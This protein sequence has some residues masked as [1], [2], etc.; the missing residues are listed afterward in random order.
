MVEVVATSGAVGATRSRKEKTEALADL[1][2]RVEV[3]ELATVVGFLAGEPRQGK[4]GV[5]WASVFGVDV[6]AA[7]EPR[8]EIAEI[9][10][11][12]DQLA[13][14]S[15]EGSQAARADQLA[16][17]MGRATV[18]EQDF[19]RRLFLGDMRHGALAGLMADAVAKAAGVPAKV[20]RRATML[21]GDLGGSAVLAMTGGRD[22]LAD[23]RLTPLR[24][25]Q[26]MLAGTAESPTAAIERNAVSSVEWKLDGVRIQVHRSGNDVRVFTRNLNDVTERMADVVDAA[27]A[28]DAESVVLDGEVVGVGPDGRPRPFQE[29]MSDFGRD[30]AESAA[31]DANVAEAEQKSEAGASWA[32]APFY[33]D[34]L[35]RDGRDLIDL[36]LIARRQELEA[37]VPEGQ[38]VPAVITGDADE[39]ERFFAAAVDAGHEGVVIKKDDSTYEAGRRGKTWLKVKPVHTLDLVVLAAEWGHGRRQGWLS[40]LHLG[41][42]DPESGE[43][44]MLGKTFKGLTDA[45]LTWQ[46]ERFLEIEDRRSSHIVFVRPELVVEIAFDG[47]MR[48]SRYPGGVSLRFARVKRYREDKSALDADTLAAVR[49][50]L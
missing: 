2:R 12:F 43:F 22:A 15:G 5:G 37:V 49:A 21:S 8:L 41:A 31:P 35:H 45:L 44:I 16:A 6:P 3:D 25:I 28:L 1:F 11:A 42:R 4:I 20:V 46:T 48:S 47:V 38:R 13:V 19:L 9:D 14:T 10:D 7:A 29:T 36:P 18:D 32:L 26:P 33:F 39:A 17:L 23:V 34:I 50:H 27:L 30:E 24:S 40:N